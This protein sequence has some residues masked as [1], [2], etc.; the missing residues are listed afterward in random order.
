VGCRLKGCPNLHSAASQSATRARRPPWTQST[1]SKSHKAHINASFLQVL[2]VV[3]LCSRHH[4]PVMPASSHSYLLLSLVLFALAPIASSKGWAS[5]PA[6]VSRIINDVID[7][8]LYVNI[9]IG[10][11][12]QIHPVTISWAESRLISFSANCPF[13]PGAF[14]FDTTQSS[15]FKVRLPLSC[16]P[17]CH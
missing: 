2:H 5:M 14:L 10:T 17:D 11:P 8:A 15:T 7:R 12:P 13:C 4:L 9:T 3:A 16:P 6:K 1:G